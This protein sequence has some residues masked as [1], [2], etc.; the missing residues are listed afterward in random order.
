LLSTFDDPG[1][2]AI[3]GP[4]GGLGASQG[5]H[6]SRVAGR[7]QTASV[8]EKRHKGHE[9]DRRTKSRRWYGAPPVSGI[10]ACRRGALLGL[11]C[12]ALCILFA[13]PSGA[14]SAGF[15]QQAQAL[16]DEN[17]SLA[18]ES[19]S[20]VVQL[21]ALDSRLTVAQ[22]QVESLRSQIATVDQQRA[23]VRRRV[24]EVRRLVK[25]AL[26][27]LSR[28]LVTIYEQGEPDALAVVLGSA[29][30]GDA[31]TS[32]DHLHAF[33]GQ[34]RNMLEQGRR[35]RAALRR[36]TADLAQRESRLESLEQ[37]ASDAVDALAQARTERSGYLAELASKR[38]LN[39]QEIAS[40]ESRARAAEERS[41][42]LAAQAA[43]APPP[44]P[45]TP[46]APPPPPTPANPS[47]RALTVVATAYSGAGSTATGLPTGPG[48]VAVD[49]TVIPLGTHLTI[50][51]YGE[52]VAAD[53]GSAIKGARIDVW[54]PTEAQAEQWG[55]Q[56]VTIYLH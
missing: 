18:A 51:G 40:L 15:R 54:V 27:N 5:R 44:A 7:V 2:P 42:E 23:S 29:S 43:L 26:Q 25:V 24:A 56:T 6:P 14:D 9:V 30:I 1:S 17:A 32:L 20:T 13:T 41:R 36:L 33:A 52:G 49:P 19:H 10:R 37:Q 11:L 16:R 4:R 21:Y 3:S 39:D 22:A 47:G 34:D 53:T 55:I 50:P 28:R 12:A 35:A 31:L 45:V 8:R 48:I 38:R 46:V